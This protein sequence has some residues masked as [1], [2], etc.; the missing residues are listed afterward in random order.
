MAGLILVAVGLALLVAWYLR[1]DRGEQTRERLLFGLEEEGPP[2]QEDLLDPAYGLGRLGRWA[3]RTTQ[4]LSS[5]QGRMGLV[6]LGGGLA[7]GVALWGGRELGDS[8]LVAAATGLMLM[9]LV[10]YWLYRRVQQRAQRIRRE[11]PY[12]LEMLAAL[13]KGGLAFDTALKHLL[14]QADSRHPLYFELATLL[15]AMQRGRRR[16]EAFRLLARRCNQFDVSDVATGLIQADQ[17]GASLSEVMRHH[18]RQ[19]FREVEAEILQ[20]AERLPVRLMFPT[21][22][23]VFPAILTVVLLPSLLRILRVI[24]ELLGKTADQIGG[25]IP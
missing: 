6:A 4:F 12:A 20:R 8:A 2:P 3:Q 7:F 16:A 13:M 9:L 22:L 18:A 15:E 10:V 24:D 17:T 25:L 1:M 23:T 5:W 14:S 11:L 21:L 19:I